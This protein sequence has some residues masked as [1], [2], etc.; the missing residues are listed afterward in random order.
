M[1][2]NSPPVQRAG[3]AV[4]AKA[5]EFGKSAAGKASAT[6]DGAAKKARNRV[7]KVNV[8]KVSQARQ[9]GLA[10]RHGRL[11]HATGRH[12]AVGQRR[13]QDYFAQ[14]LARRLAG[15]GGTVANGS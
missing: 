7:A 13:P 15:N 5:A 6:A 12:P 3:H 9:A 4:A 11:G 14:R 10:V 8:P 2:V 1:A